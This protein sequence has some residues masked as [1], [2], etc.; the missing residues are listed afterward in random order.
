VTTVWAP[1]GG[2][3]LIGLSVAMLLL[4]DG[5]VAGI[6]GIV[7][8]VIRPSPGEWSWRA[9]FLL[10]L[11]AGGV[12]G[13]IAAPGAIGAMAAPAGALV[14]AGLLVGFGTRLAEGCTSGHGVC[15]VSR[16][17]LRSI[18]ATATFMV[19]AAI[20]VFVMRRVAAR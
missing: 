5:R 15:G 14:P 4:L 2:G 20:V 1:L 11:I 12:V 7:A 9:F 16:G 13:Q 17:S 6:S 8:G 10:G 19:T 3:L 18:A